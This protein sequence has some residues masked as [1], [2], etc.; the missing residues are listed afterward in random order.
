MKSHTFRE[1]SCVSWFK[2]SRDASATR[3]ERDK[4]D[5]RAGPD[6]D[7]CVVAR[8]DRLFVELD[9]DR[10]AL[11]TEAGKQR[12]HAERALHRMGLTIELDAVVHFHCWSCSGKGQLLQSEKSSRQKSWYTCSKAW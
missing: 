3:S 6:F 9:D 10:L 4:L 2:Q 1:I 11:E 7:A 5:L 8:E 12:A